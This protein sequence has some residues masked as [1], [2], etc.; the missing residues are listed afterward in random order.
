MKHV[1]GTP[2]KDII[3]LSHGPVGCTYDTWQTKRY[4]SDN[5]IPMLRV[6]FPVYDRAGYY[7]HPV[8]G[9][10]GAMWLAE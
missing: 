7:R 8:V 1:I 10:A 2:M 4:L 5:D 3:H 6:G 9:Y